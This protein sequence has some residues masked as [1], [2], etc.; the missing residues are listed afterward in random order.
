MRSRYAY[1]FG[2]LLGLAMICLGCDND[3]SSP[4]ADASTDSKLT[5]DGPAVKKDGPAVKKDGPAVKKD[6]LA[7]KK[8]GP[9]VK[10]D[11]SLDKGTAK[12]DASISSGKWT[13]AEIAACKKSIVAAATSSG[14]T[15]KE[16]LFVGGF[17]EALGTLD[18][19][20]GLVI[21]TFPLQ[22]GKV[23]GQMVNTYLDCKG[24]LGTGG[25]YKGTRTGTS[26][27]GTWTMRQLAGVFG[28]TWK[29]TAKG[30]GSAQIGGTYNVTSGPKTSM[31]CNNP[32]KS[33]FGVT[34]CYCA[35]PGSWNTVKKN[36]K[37][38]QKNIPF[39][40]QNGAK[41]TFTSLDNP[42][43]AKVDESKKAQRYAIIDLELVCE[44]KLP[45]IGICPNLL[46]GNP[47]NANYTSS[48]K[49]TLPM[50]KIDPV[51][52]A[53]CP[54]LYTQPL[55]KGRWYAAVGIAGNASTAGLVMSDLEVLSFQVFKY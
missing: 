17:Q 27:S 47:M 21:A 9:A 11:L 1:V 25:T 36:E 48:C 31:K 19:T 50:A 46:N 55:V 4:A 41:L 40:V 37:P 15:A 52:A 32:D 22:N 44:N 2:G 42:N 14:S 43:T 7:V 49:V 54:C 16:G 23:Y 3:D 18:P 33:Q 8:D 6:G 51:K 12:P 34:N 29:G 45:L 13:V 38:T 30:A 20:S 35:S 53:L 10:K 26:L 5:K 39:S 24:N 28:G